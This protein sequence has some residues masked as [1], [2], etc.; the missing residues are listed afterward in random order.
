MQIMAGPP[1]PVT[2]ADR[3][4]LR[5]DELQDGYRLACQAEVWDD[6]TV[7]GAPAVED[8]AF[9][10]LVDGKPRPA[11]GGLSLDS[12]V[13]QVFAIVPPP[14][15]YAH[16]DSDL[17]ALLRHLGA[18]VEE[19]PL[20]VLQ[21]LP[22]LLRAAPQGVT[23]TVFD[24]NL[25]TLEAGDVRGEA[26]GL[27]FDV[28]TTTVVGYLADLSS[29]SVVAT[30]SDVNPQEAFGADL[31]S[32]IAFVQHR[33]E[34]VRHLRRLILRLLN[35]QIRE[36]CARAGIR[37]DR[38]YKTVVAGNTVMHHLVAGID[39]TYVGQA[40]YAPGVRRGLQ[41][42]ARELGLRLNPSTPVFFLPIVAGYVGADAVAMVL[43]TRIYANSQIRL[44]VDIGTNGE[45]VIGS[46]DGLAACSAPAG[47][48]LEGG[49][50]HSGLRG[51]RGAIDRVRIDQTV[52][53]HV[54]GDGP[55]MG[56]CGSGVLDA[57]AGLLDAG[58]LDASGR[59]R[60]DPPSAAHDALRRRII[61]LPDGSPA[62]VIV[63][64]TRGGT[65]RD[66]LL[67]QADIR[68]IQLAKAAIRSG[69]TMLQQ[70]TDTPDDRIAELLLA[71][72][73]GNYLSVRSALRVGLIPPVPPGR[74]TCIG[75][76]AGLGA[77]MALVSETERRRA[78]EL[79][80][81]IRHHSLATHPRF[82]SVFA[83]A[84]QF[85]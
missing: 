64:A 75:N 36:T 61:E 20:A 68:Q 31:I 12:G 8:A 53:C 44:C 35:E 10:I 23:A 72:G 15:D 6:L 84:L 28:G 42:T 69:I 4:Q 22:S 32:R 54:I 14:S 73:F 71:G 2:I 81:L 65:G 79:A 17:E 49:R 37:E 50:L 66:I 48:A 58:I 41:V 38:I 30:A 67:T 33:P 78:D 43:A 80:R 29:G 47:P 26:Y 27:A 76:A 62:F 77:Q 19:V 5:E 74:V 60:P 70:L 18:Y 7:L 85:P 59:L 46:Q 11:V 1:P 24:H 9:Q 39:P 51:T 56:I 52:H 57:I 55:P 45:M 82:Q 25:M 3:V 16:A 63:P 21:H 40:P 13:S 83:G 34:N